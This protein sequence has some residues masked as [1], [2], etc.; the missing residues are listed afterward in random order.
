MV[1]NVKL[2]SLFGENRSNEK[3]EIKGSWKSSS[4]IADNDGKWELKLATP[5]AGGPFEVVANDSKS[6][7]AYRDVSIGEVW[8]ASGRQ[9]CNGS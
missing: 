3:I 8:L 2:R 9:T 4:V 6:S 7:I 1:Y 5:S